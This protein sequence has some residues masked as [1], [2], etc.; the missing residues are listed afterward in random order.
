MYIYI[1]PILNC[2]ATVGIGRSRMTSAHA[3]LYEYVRS[4]LCLS[5]AECQALPES[6]THTIHRI[7]TTASHNNRT[8]IKWRGT[9]RSQIRD[10]NRN[11]QHLH[12]ANFTVLAWSW[13][14]GGVGCLFNVLYLTS[15][16]TVLFYYFIYIY[17]YNTVR[18]ALY[19]IANTS[20]PNFCTCNYYL[21]ILFYISIFQ[22]QFTF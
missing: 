6:S 4:C 22:L 5:K 3:L 10:I 11:T 8:I 15:S 19:H 1:Y 13:R 14:N 7:T 2:Y 21:I 20:T 18:C 16:C 17:I 9:R 12:S